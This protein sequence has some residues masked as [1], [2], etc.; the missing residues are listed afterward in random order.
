MISLFTIQQISNVIYLTDEGFLISILLMIFFVELSNTV[1]IFSYNALTIQQQEKL[2]IYASLI[3]FL[4]ISK[5]I[6]FSLFQAGPILICSAV[7]NVTVSLV[8]LFF[9]VKVGLDSKSLHNIMVMGYG[10]PFY[11]KIQKSWDHIQH[12]V[13]ELIF[14]LEIIPFNYTIV[15]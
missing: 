11:P 6:F 5:K 9:I 15:V 13:S 3:L 10:S 4:T 2:S 7:L 12:N 14:R 1:L 8:M